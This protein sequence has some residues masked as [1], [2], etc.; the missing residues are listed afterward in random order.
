MA[1]IVNTLIDGLTSQ[2]VQARLNSVD[3]KPFL[4]G[5]HFPVKKVNGFVWRTLGNQ[6]AK[7]N[8]AADLHTDNGTVLRKR[9]PLFE[10]A[11]GDIPFISISR[12]KA[13][14][15]SEKSFPGKRIRK[16]QVYSCKMDIAFWYCCFFQ[17]SS[18]L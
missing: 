1:T 17:V 5:T 15:L 9:R 7:K 11:K 18:N 8:V 16:N 10:S 13:H 14:F 3:A 6:L 4:F 2:M 12:W